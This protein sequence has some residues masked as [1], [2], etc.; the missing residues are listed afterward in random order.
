MRWFY[1]GKVPEE[2]RHWFQEKLGR[3]HLRS[4]EVREDVYLWVPQCEFLGVKHRQGRLEIKWR[5]QQLGVWSISDRC[6]GNAEI[7]IK[8]LCVDPEGDNMLP[9]NATSQSFDQAQDRPTWIGVQK[10]RQQRMYACLEN[11]QIKP[12]TADEWVSCGG[13]VELTQLTVAEKD[14]WTLGV[15]VFG[16]GRD[17]SEVLKAIASTVTASYTGETISADHSFGYPALLAR[18]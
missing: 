5:Q 9:A 4:P 16:E 2:V 13:G 1:P 12:I 15:E 10:K 14:W 11:H 7:W 6:S 18:L 3:D 8:W 17:L